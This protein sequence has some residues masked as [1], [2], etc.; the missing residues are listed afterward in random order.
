MHHSYIY[1]NMF[2]YTCMC[3]CTHTYSLWYMSPN[4]YC[5]G[6]IGFSKV[7]ILFIYSFIYLT[8]SGLRCGTGSSLCH[9]G[10]FTVVHRLSSCGA[11]ASCSAAYGILVPQPGIKPPSLALQDRFLN[12]WTTKEVP[13]LLLYRIFFPLIIHFYCFLY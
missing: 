12:H 1:E 7:F 10:S 13:N 9:V 2:I 3:L 4:W 8:T 11:W 5:S 6:F